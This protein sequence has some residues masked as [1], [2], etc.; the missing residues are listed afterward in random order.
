[1]DDELD[2]MATEVRYML[3]DRI[4]YA[5]GGD[6]VEAEFIALR[7]PTS[8]HAETCAAIEQAFFRASREAAS[9]SEPTDETDE[10]TPEITGADIM[11]GIAA[12]TSV[13]LGDVLKAGRA[14]FQQPGIA[15]LDGETAIKR[16][17]LD[18]MSLRD[19]KAM[20]GQYVR[21]FLIASSLQRMSEPSSKGS[22]T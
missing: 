22:A 16:K 3:E 11:M 4:S 17:N 15:L 14:L 21:D 10:P 1:M 8:Q 5:H 18:D 12:S 7:A 9:S 2:T 20:L 6:Q 19:F 13:D